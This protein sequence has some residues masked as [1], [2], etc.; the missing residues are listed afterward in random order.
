MRTL[1]RGKLLL[2][3]A[4]ITAGL[5]LLGPQSYGQEGQTKTPVEVAI[6]YNPLL[7]NV[8]SANR[9]WMQG[10]SIQVNG[11]LWHGWGVMTDVSG[12]HA[13]TA[14]NSGV[15]LDLVTTT[16]GPRYRWSRPGRRYGFFGQALVGRANGFHSLFPGPGAAASSASSLAVQLGGGIDLPM[17]HRLSLRAFEADWLR[18]QLPNATTNVQNNLRLAMGLTVRFP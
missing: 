1:I 7:S 18:T 9:F 3:G 5:S 4:C 16:F 13:Q 2:A 6:L 14:S 15:G 8:V 17:K 12:L 11:Q 10:G